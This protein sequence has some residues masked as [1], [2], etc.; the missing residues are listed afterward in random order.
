M[1]HH[2]GRN[3]DAFARATQQ[4]AGEYLFRNIVAMPISFIS[5]TLAT[6][7]LIVLDL[8]PWLDHFPIPLM[9]LQTFLTPRSTTIY[10]N[11]TILTFPVVKP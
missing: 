4:P 3:F 6:F 9:R 2:H 1:K 11:S 7:G 8:L 10:R 5:C